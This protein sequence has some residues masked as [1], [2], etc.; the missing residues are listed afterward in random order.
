MSGGN[1]NSV[2]RVSVTLNQTHKRSQEPDSMDAFFQD[3]LLDEDAAEQ[4]EPQNPQINSAHAEHTP[5]ANDDAFDDE[6]LLDDEM[7]IVD[8]LIEDASI[9]KAASEADDSAIDD[10]LDDSEFDDDMQLDQL[11]VFMSEDPDKADDLL[12]LDDVSMDE[13]EDL[14][15][16]LNTELEKAPLTASQQALEA[17]RAIEERAERRRMERDLN[18]L[19]FELDD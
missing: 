19:D 13:D 10:D 9:D 7:T 4:D 15:P 14:D 5:D 2:M 11:D 6:E 16:L 1:R 18:Y 12:V 17:R 8:S 3:E